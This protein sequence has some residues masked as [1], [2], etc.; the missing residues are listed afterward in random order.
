MNI[1]VTNECPVESAKFLDDKR[2]IK[3]ILESAQ[4][5]STAV[6]LHGGPQGGLYRVTHINHPCTVWVSATQGNY[7]WL[8]YHYQALMAEYFHRFGKRHKSSILQYELLWGLKYIPKGDLQPFVNCTK[9]KY[10]P[11]FRAYQLC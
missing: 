8:Y 10:I 5:L 9:Y 2:V 11:V 4:M 3:M 1:F 6:Q 7:L